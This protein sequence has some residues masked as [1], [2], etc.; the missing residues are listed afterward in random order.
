MHRGAF[1]I[2][3]RYGKDMFLYIQAF[4]TDKVPRAFAAKSRFDGITEKAG[5][6]NAVSDR[7]L[8]GLSRLLQRGD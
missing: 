4:G 3:R 1:D 2:S 6:G 5:L 8:Q 7:L